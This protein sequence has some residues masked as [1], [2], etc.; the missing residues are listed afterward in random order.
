M[1]QINKNKL[2]LLGIIAT[3]LISLTASITINNQASAQTANFETNYIEFT[4][5]KSV[6][7]SENTYFKKVEFPLGYSCY[8]ATDERIE[9]F[10]T[11]LDLEKKGDSAVFELPA[12]SNISQIMIFFYKGDERQYNITIQGAEDGAHYPYNVAGAGWEKIFSGKTK[13]VGLGEPVIISFN[14]PKEA[15]FLR[16]IGYGNYLDGQSNIN[17]AHTSIKEIKFFGSNTDE[18]YTY[19]NSSP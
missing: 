5:L 18:V 10:G 11:R 1:K 6:Y 4:E 15:Q 12:V 19:Q 3:I 16:I 14:T 9:G 13:N 8:K 7:C 17:N 2:L